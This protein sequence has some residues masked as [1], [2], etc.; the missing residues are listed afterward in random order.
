MKYLGTYYGNLSSPYLIHHLRDVTH[1]LKIGVEDY[2]YDFYQSDK[3]LMEATRCQIP[4]SFQLMPTMFFPDHQIVEN[5][6]YL[7]QFR[8]IVMIDSF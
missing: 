1:I 2:P 3:Y 8:L 6:L 7:I 4:S 5:S